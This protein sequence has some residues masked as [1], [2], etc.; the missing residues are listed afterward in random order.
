MIAYIHPISGSPG[1]P[2]N[3][4]PG[5]G[6]LPPGW[7][8][9][10]PG[11]EI[12]PPNGLPPLPPIE[13]LPPG[14]WTKPPGEGLWPITPPDWPIVIPI[15]P[16]KPEPGLPP[17]PGHPLPEPPTVGGGPVLPVEIWPPLPPSAGIAGHCLVLVWMVGV[18]Y[19]WLVM[20]KAQVTPPIAETPEPK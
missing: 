6:S 2:D 7:W 15:P 3:S 13:G 17:R 20:D 14:W 5:G 16:E 8:T 9:K 18:G 1:E 11:N 19:R 10:P 4:L 12:W